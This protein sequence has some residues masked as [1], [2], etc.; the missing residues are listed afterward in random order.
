MAQEPAAQDL[1]A[2]ALSRII[3]QYRNKP[4]L[5]AT[6][7]ADVQPMQELDDCALQIPLLYDIDGA[8][9]VNLDKLGQLVGQSRVLINGSIV[10]DAQYRL[11]IRARIARNISHATGEDIISQLVLIFSAQVQLTDWMGMAIGY[12]I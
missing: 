7:S 8:T 5:A 10:T 3:T 2:Q 9:G 11:L 1:V 6:I 4:N 12:A